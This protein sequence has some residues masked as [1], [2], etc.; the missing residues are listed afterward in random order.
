MDNFPLN[1][2]MEKQKIVNILLILYEKHIAFWNWVDGPVIFIF[3]YLDGSVNLNM[4]SNLIATQDV[5]ND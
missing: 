2:F 3:S 1:F 4:S 5:Y